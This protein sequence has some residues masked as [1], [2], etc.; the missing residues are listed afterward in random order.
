MAEPESK[1]PWRAVTHLLVVEGRDGGALLN[2]TL[3]CGHHKTIA[4]PGRKK[5]HSARCH[6]CEPARKPPR[7]SAPKRKSDRLP[8]RQECP[9]GL[10]VGDALFC[11]QASEIDGT[12]QL[13]EWIVR[14]IEMPSPGASGLRPYASIWIKVSLSF[15]PNTLEAASVLDEA[16]SAEMRRFEVGSPLPEG[17]YNSDRAA[18]LF[19]VSKLV[20]RHKQCL[21]EVDS[22]PSEIWRVKAQATAE[23]VCKQLVHMRALKKKAARRHTLIASRQQK[24][25]LLA[26][27]S[28]HDQN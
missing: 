23:L 8:P 20:V 28:G 7:Q 12:A 6:E 4:D 18:L 17:V 3:D 19:A 24:N 2:L 5:Q 14:S 26:A 21:A 25:R 10:R 1:A 13:D 22:A 16:P 27:G 15:L 11:A 9:I